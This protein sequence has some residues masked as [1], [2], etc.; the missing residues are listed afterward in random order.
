MFRKTIAFIISS[1]CILTASAQFKSN[2]TADKWVDSIFKTLSP[3]EKTMM[4]KL[5]KSAN[6]Q[7]GE[8]AAEQREDRSF[9]DKIKDAFGG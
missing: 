3:D 9:F 4:D 8:N 6:F 5:S 2:L 1:I 7:P